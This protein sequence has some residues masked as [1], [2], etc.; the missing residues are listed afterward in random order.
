MKGFLA[1][2]GKTCFQSGLVLSHKHRLPVIE[3]N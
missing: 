3:E 2:L 1:Y